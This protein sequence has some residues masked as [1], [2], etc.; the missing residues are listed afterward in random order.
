MKKLFILLAAFVL[1]LS[2]CDDLMNPGGDAKS[3]VKV[4]SA[5]SI[6]GVTISDLTIDTT[7]HTITATV[8]Y[9]TVLT[10]LVPDISFT[11]ASISP[12]SGTQVDFSSPVTFTITAEDGSKMEY[13]VTIV[14]GEA[15][16]YVGTW[17]AEAEESINTLVLNADGTWEIWEDENESEKETGTY[18]VSD[19]TVSIVTDGDTAIGTYTY[20]ISNGILSF[21]LVSDADEDRQSIALM[22]W[23]QTYSG[24]VTLIIGT[25]PDYEPFEF[26][27]DNDELTGFDI[28]VMNEIASRNNYQITW[29]QMNFE[30]LFSEI[31]K[32]NIDAAIAGITVTDEREQY[33]LFSTPYY[34]YSS[35]EDYAVLFNMS[36]TQL[37]AD[38]DKALAAMKSDGTFSDLE[39]SYPGLSLISSL[40]FT[41][42]ALAQAVADT[43]VLHVCDLT[44]L[45][46]EG[47]GI[48]DL[49]GIES[50]V[51]LEKLYLQDNDIS[52]ITKLGE[53][54]RL[55]NL[56]LDD[57]SISDISAL[58]YLVNLE[59]L[60]IN[61]NG[62]SDI[63]VVEKFVN[64]KRLM[65]DDNDISDIS[66][67]GELE[68]L[69]SLRIGGNTGI[70][71]ISVVSSLPSLVDF[72]MGNCSVSDFSPLYS[73]PLKKLRIGEMGIS[74]ISFLSNF[75]DLSNLTVL[76]LRWNE[77][78]DISYLSHFTKLEDLD[79]DYNRISDF[80]SVSG[81]TNLLQLSIGYNDF[82]DLDFIS[83]LKS[84]WHLEVY[85]S[86]VTD[87]SPIKTLYDNGAFQS[88][89]EHEPEIDIHDCDL[90]LTIGSANREI[91]DYL[92]NK[93]IKFPNWDYG[94]IT[95]DSSDE[96][97]IAKLY[98][99][100]EPIGY[101]EDLD[102]IYDDVTT[103]SD[104]NF[105]HGYGDEISPDGVDEF[106]VYHRSLNGTEVESLYN[107]PASLPSDLT[108]IAGHYT[109]DNTLA[110]SSS[111]SGGPTAEIADFYGTMEVDYI[112]D[113]ASGTALSLS[114]SRGDILFDSTI[115]S[116]SFNGFSIN[117]WV[118]SASLHDDE[119]IS[120][121]NSWKGYVDDD[122][123]NIDIRNGFL[124]FEGGMFS[125]SDYGEDE[126]HMIT[127]VID[128]EEAD[129]SFPVYNTVS[130]TVG[131]PESVNG[132]EFV[133]CLDD[134]YD[135]TD[136]YYMS[137]MDSFDGS[138]FDYTLTNVVDG[139]YFVYAA[140]D[141]DESWE[142]DGGGLSNGD[143][144]GYYGTSTGTPPAS[145]PLS[146]YGDA[147]A[148]FSL[149]EYTA[150]VSPDE[151]STLLA[152][153]L[154]SGNADDTSGNGNDG[155]VYGA[156]LTTDRDGN[157]NSAYSFDG[158]DGSD[159]IGVTLND[160]LRTDSIS[161]SAWIL[162]NELENDWMDII[163]YSEYGHV[164]A[165]EET[166]FILGG[167]QG[168]GSSGEFAGTTD[169][170][171]SQWH[172]IV[173]TR[174]SSNDIK[175]YVDN[176]LEVEETCSY[177]PQYGNSA[178]YIGRCPSYGEEFNGKIDDVRIYSGVLTE[179]EI[180]A[181]YNE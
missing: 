138:S 167:L 147:V 86:S 134:N 73:L 71:N 152:E 100:G 104:I 69:S 171:D 46:C 44:E 23:S 21:T 22:N 74:D 33:F 70:N 97:L 77:I 85:G 179:S 38:M 34:D 174:N 84:L 65:A 72:A 173:F 82:S 6:N 13:K 89:D 50:L 7:N 132:K 98:F 19:S 5:F 56:Y 8:P 109:F 128:S 107:T 164:L 176:V 14:A 168:T 18:T 117:I 163:S 137:T 29:I 105:S 42:S 111:A 9:G 78:T 139:D 177:N 12:A 24:E 45:N 165:V 60:Y 91:V 136:G 31:A 30:D 36:D 146:C 122:F 68:Y 25:C 103:A 39:A 96:D 51:C 67:V 92:M 57:N 144:W 141:M 58:E 143:Y 88:D 151:D 54:T 55:R 121:L 49:S 63:S 75:S 166:G 180:A 32:G 130:G 64:L 113:S 2:S 4:I 59:D 93:S 47:L 43:D 114:G 145:V 10:A 79:L 169:L 106:L 112:S 90:D 61:N 148:D 76:K 62:V 119:F 127:L 116:D 108:D 126:W 80:S 156:S 1:F 181:L 20:T 129:D 150:A 17:Y 37:K 125:L 170:D 110:S 87:L 28:D 26:L 133:V 154:F 153:Y 83:S 81:M 102:R 160:Y 142:S 161:F 140:V 66:P 162:I 40:S 159:Y 172:H 131:I 27:D 101:V 94:N 135:Y 124:S 149:V 41:D 157:V 118:K 48:S 16:D 52:D 53:L 95:G 11:G 15:P 155:T 120:I 35:D 158:Y 123:F 175:V 99:D 178:L 115:L 3:S